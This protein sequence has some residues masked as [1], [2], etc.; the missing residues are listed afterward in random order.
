MSLTVVELELANSIGIATEI[1][2]IVKHECNGTLKQLS[3]VTDDYQLQPI[4]GLSV[5][6]R[7]SDVQ[8]ILAS[9]QPRLTP[10]GYR[11]FWSERCDT[12]G[13]KESD[14]IA[15]AR[16]DSD[17]FILGIRRPNGANYGLS[18]DDV[19]NKIQDWK[20]RCQCQVVGAATDWVA[21]DFET[22]PG[23]ACRFAEE[24]Y[25]FCPDTVEQGVGL[26][27]EAD[28]PETFAAA[29]ALCPTLSTEMQQKIDAQTARF[30]KMVL[31]PQLRQMVDAGLAFGTPT[32]MGVRLLAY[33]LEQSRQLFLW[34]D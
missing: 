12:N 8:P 15:V 28:Q 6:V 24:V 29:R 5:A 23:G 10:F 3:V 13:R 14:E 21:I 30:K 2:E 1:C 34:W 17:T 19:A 25:N 32:D 16:T 26:M 31:P 27:N 7:R 33:S 4:A 18:P 9:L 11:A 20:G 22:L